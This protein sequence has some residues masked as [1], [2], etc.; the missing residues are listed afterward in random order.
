[1]RVF[2]SSI[3]IIFAC[4]GQITLKIEISLQIKYL[5]LRKNKEIEITKNY[6]ILCDLK[7][8]TSRVF[9]MFF[10]HKYR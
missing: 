2:D 8:F 9:V 10:S 4:L 3:I 1:M 5:T 6:G 7:M